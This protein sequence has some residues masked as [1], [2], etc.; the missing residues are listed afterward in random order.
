MAI[1][2]DDL[3]LAPVMDLFGE[4]ERGS[5]STWPTYYPAGGGSFQLEGAV[6]D[7]AYQHTEIVGD[8][9]MVTTSPVL[10]VRA[11]LFRAPPAQGETVY[12]PSAG[13]IYAVANP[14][15]DGHGH[16]LLVLM[17]TDA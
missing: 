1:D 7:A 12:I 14:Q 11:C 2:W 16:V 6:F 4:G 13:R 9:S 5:P 15:P 17:E 8:A 3:V 10:G